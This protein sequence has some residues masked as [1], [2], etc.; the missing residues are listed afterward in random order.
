MIDAYLG[1]ARTASH[2]AFA[3]KREVHEQL[4]RSRTYGFPGFSSLSGVTKYDSCNVLSRSHS[5]TNHFTKLLFTAHQASMILLSAQKKTKNIPEPTLLTQA[6][7]DGTCQRTKPTEM[8]IFSESRL[9]LFIE[10]P[11][12]EESKA[13]MGWLDFPAVSNDA[14][15]DSFVFPEVRKSLEH[16]VQRIAVPTTSTSKN[17]EQRSARRV[18]FG[19]VHIREHAITVGE[20]DWCDGRLPLTLDWKHAASRSMNIEDYECI[21]ER[22]QRGHL[23]RLDYWHRKRLLIKVSDFKEEEL[24]EIENQQSSSEDTSSIRLRRSRTVSKSLHSAD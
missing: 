19:S 6:F 1:Q 11:A 16:V 14:E 18:R 9:P 22:S 23:Y 12:P 3:A 24:D 15:V 20:H 8:T 21:R 7:L 17:S 10:R 4:R 2:W 5:L 13:P